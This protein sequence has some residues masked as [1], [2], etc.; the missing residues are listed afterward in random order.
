MVKGQQY[1]NIFGISLD[2]WDLDLD[3]FHNLRPGSLLR[4][5]HHQ[6]ST[7]CVPRWTMTKRLQNDGG[8]FSIRW[9]TDTTNWC[10]SM[11]PEAGSKWP[12]N[13]WKHELRTNQQ[14][15]GT[16]ERPGGWII[17]CQPE[18]SSCQR[19]SVDSWCFQKKLRV[20]NS[21]PSLLSSSCAMPGRNE[22]GTKRLTNWKMVLR[23]K[24]MVLPGASIL[25]HGPAG[26]ALAILRKND[27][28]MTR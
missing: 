2:D 13:I 14:P 15:F 9:G 7:S 4:Y 24:N 18:G 1:S 6:I 12:E 5:K 17:C 11:L 3:W 22:T 26:P 23:W 20:E 10:Q 8:N 16:C 25:N 28:V 27:Q 19:G 21:S